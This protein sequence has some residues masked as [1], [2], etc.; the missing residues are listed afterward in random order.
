[1]QFDNIAERMILGMSAIYDL[2]VYDLDVELHSIYL[3]DFLDHYTDIFRHIMTIFRISIIFPTQ[4]TFILR[5]IQS[6]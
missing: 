3:S 6:T 5:I 2:R 4:P 1:M